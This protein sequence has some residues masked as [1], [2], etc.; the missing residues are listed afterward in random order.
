MSHH[1]EY[2]ES[3]F[4]TWGHGDK[5]RIFAYVWASLPLCTSCMV[6]GPW[7]WVIKVGFASVMKYVQLIRNSSATSKTSNMLACKGKKWSSHIWSTYDRIKKQQQLKSAVRRSGVALYF[8]FL[9]MK[10]WGI[11]CAV[12]LRW[13]NCSLWLRWENDIFRTST[14]SPL[15]TLCECYGEK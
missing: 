3:A 11:F 4:I 6:C 10:E 1:S 15:C 14:H 9:Q 7:W 12:C 2:G 5:G 8:P 13:H